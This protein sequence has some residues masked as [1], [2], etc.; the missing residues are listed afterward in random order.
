MSVR[1][2]AIYPASTTS[3][4]L[5]GGTAGLRPPLG[6]SATLRSITPGFRLG[7]RCLS[8]ALLWLLLTPLPLL[9][10]G[11]AGLGQAEQRFAMPDPDRRLDFPADHAAHPGFRIEWWYV[12]AN[13]SGADGKEYGVQWTLFRSAL[14]PGGVGD[15]G[16]NTPQAWMGHAALTTPT[17]HFVAE[18]L[19]RG[20]IGQA[21][22]SLASGFHAWIDEWELAGASI[23][24]LTMR[25]TG[26]DFAYDLALHADGPLV[27]QGVGGFSVKS[28]S[29]QASRYYSQ[30]FYHVTGTLT[31]PNGAVSVT[32]QAWLDRE[33][34][35]QLL[36]AEQSGWD[37]ISLHFDSGAKLMGFTL[38]DTAGDFTSATWIAPDGT[39][40]PYGDGAL[41]LTPLATHD[42]AGHDVPVTWRVELPA[43]GVDFTIEAVNPDAWMA[44]SVPYWEGPVRISGSESGRGY[45]EMT[46]YD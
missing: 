46:G 21:G 4:A 6:S 13:L 39:P 34:S 1:P 25:A 12:T 35:S 24:S 41:T 17:R 26:S 22:V 38:H 42:A 32:G 3:G 28:A 37:W 15:Q 18:R 5:H 20:G 10:Q 19:A 31:L 2:T 36:D 29:G 8:L 11:F 33:W 14:A 16:W 40:T 23:D 7:P 27:L 43:Q 9:A 44:T 45:L 30:P